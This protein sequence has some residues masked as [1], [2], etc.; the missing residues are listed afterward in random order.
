MNIRDNASAWESE[1]QNPQFLSLGTEPSGTVRD[2]A[3]W[4][5]KQFRKNRTD[6]EQS[7][8]ISTVL[9][10]GC[11]NGKNLK[12]MV[13][14]YADQGIGYD[15]SETAISQAEYLRDELL[16]EYQVRSIGETF[17]IHKCSID[18][19]MDITASNSLT[20]SEREVFLSETSRVLKPEGIFLS[21]MLC[22]DADKNAKFLIQENPG[23]QYHTY[24]LPGV[25]ITE[26]V[27]TRADIDETYGK[28]FNILHIEKTTGYQRWDDRS[29]KRNYW[30]VYFSK[31]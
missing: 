15:I 31:K 3:A 20:E 26:R 30:V 22:L 16:I 14:H 10:L 2:F 5:K 9:D 6:P 29:F 21:R 19:V 11:G 8:E 17:P 27:F 24:I 25:N 28:Y 1:Y 4:M 23:T 12:Y 13:E 18:V 7:F